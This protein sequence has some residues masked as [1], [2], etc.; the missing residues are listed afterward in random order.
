MFPFSIAHLPSA[1]PNAANRVKIL[2]SNITF[3]V[4]DFMW[5]HFYSFHLS[6]R[7]PVCLL[8]AFALPLK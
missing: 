4:L 1:I 7:V 3:L 2:N 6:V 5:V 8:I